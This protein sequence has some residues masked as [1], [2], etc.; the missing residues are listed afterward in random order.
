MGYDELV[1]NSIYEQIIEKITGGTIFGIPID[2]N[3]IKMIVVAAYCLGKNEETL[4]N[5][6]QEKRD[7]L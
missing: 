3:N 4:K 1:I 7:L 5:I 2:I 6:E